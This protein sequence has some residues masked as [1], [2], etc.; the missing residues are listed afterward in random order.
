MCAHSLPKQ[1]CNTWSKIIYIIIPLG[2]KKKNLS[3]G[4]SL[5]SVSAGKNAAGVQQQEGIICSCFSWNLV[6]FSEIISRLL[7]RPYHSDTK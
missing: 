2:E 7:L 3:R 5:L 6:V 1:Q 4:H